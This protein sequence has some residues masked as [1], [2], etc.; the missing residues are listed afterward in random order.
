MKKKPPCFSGTAARPPDRCSDRAR[1]LQPDD[2][3]KPHVPIPAHRDGRPK[4]RSTVCPHRQLPTLQ[5][6][7]IGDDLSGNDV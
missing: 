4:G 3:A 2:G 5:G 7:P 1:A 6:A